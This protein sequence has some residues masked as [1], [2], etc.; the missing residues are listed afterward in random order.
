M[1]QPE[2]DQFVFQRQLSQIQ[3]LLVAI[4][5]GRPQQS[6][7]SCTGFTEATMAFPV[8]LATRGLTQ[9]LKAGAAFA[10]FVSNCTLSH[11]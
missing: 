9:K 10:T 8:T 11:T 2:E 4:L 6:W 3:E 7:R 1:H 5:A